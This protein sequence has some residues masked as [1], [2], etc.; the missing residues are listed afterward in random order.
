MRSA[1]VGLLD[2]LSRYQ[3]RAQRACYRALPE[4]RTLETNRA[5][6]AFQVDPDD[7]P[8]VPTIVDTIE[9]T[10]TPR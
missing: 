10:K 6:R 1:T 9:S 2:R 3:A 5:L 7:L 4:L 8:E